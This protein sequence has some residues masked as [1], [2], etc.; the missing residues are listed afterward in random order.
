[1]KR[2][3]IAA[4]RA[5]RATIASSS[6][7]TSVSE[8]TTSSSL[9]R[10]S[11]ATPTRVKENISSID[12]SLED[13][14][15]DFEHNYK[16]LVESPSRP[17][18]FNADTLSGASLTSSSTLI[19]SGGNMSRSSA[20]NELMLSPSASN[21]ATLGRSRAKDIEAALRHRRQQQLVFNR[22]DT[23]SRSLS[24]TLN[25][26][27]CQPSSQSNG[28]SQQLK[29]K[30]SWLLDHKD[31]TSAPSVLR[32]SDITKE[33]AAP[34][35][36]R[37]RNLEAK[38]QANSGLH[39]IDVSA[40]D[41]NDQKKKIMSKGSNVM[42]AA[43][44]LEQ[45]LNPMQQEVRLKEKACDYRKKTHDIKVVMKMTKE[46]DWNKKCWEERE[47]QAAGKTASFA[48]H[49]VLS[50]DGGSKKA[51]VSSV[52]SVRIREII[53]KI[54]Q[55]ASARANWHTRSP[56]S[57]R[58]FTI[59]RCGEASYCDTAFM[60]GKPFRFGEIRDGD[61]DRERVTKLT[62]DVACDSDVYSSFCSFSCSLFSQFSSFCLLIAFALIFAYFSFHYGLK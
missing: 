32:E 23:S 14:L 19:N 24:S 59:P 10:E 3:S 35:A 42:T 22:K 8:E 51:A 18:S 34:F 36:S 27:P 12:Q 9:L 28:A 49:G 4:K 46:T 47:K 25:D 55:P 53:H 50:E 43:T 15:A 48:L 11:E 13:T 1:M 29:S 20:F 56:F 60:S 58:R 61:G 21:L 5:R 45:L 6:P 62:N 41:Q 40:F 26:A 2:Q 54:S 57:P 17:S 52:P 33:P 16:G 38:F 30:M 39:S 37:V 7:F 44:T 31:A